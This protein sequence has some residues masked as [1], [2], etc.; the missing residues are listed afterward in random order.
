MSK[1]KFK[2]DAPSIRPIISATKVTAIPNTEDAIK[3]PRMMASGD[4]GQETS[5]SKVFACPSQG[6]M[7]GETAVDVKNNVIPSSPDIKKDMDIGLL[8]MRNAR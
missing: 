4:I 6:N 2:T 5:R 7:T 3:S 8:P 1:T